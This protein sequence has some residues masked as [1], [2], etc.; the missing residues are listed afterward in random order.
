ML[1]FVSSL[2]RPRRSSRCGREEKKKGN[3][4]CVCGGDTA[5]SE[6]IFIVNGQAG[7]NGFL[8]HSRRT[9]RKNGTRITKWCCWKFI[10]FIIMQLF[11]SCF[12][13]WSLPR[14]K[15]MAFYCVILCLHLSYNCRI[16]RWHTKAI[17]R[18]FNPFHVFM[19]RAKKLKIRFLINCWWNFCPLLA[20]RVLEADNEWK[21]PKLI[22]RYAYEQQ[23]FT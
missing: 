1:H 3:Y 5:I 2:R 18:Q 7:L 12:C 11:F 13:L 19:L 21:S 23:S 9:S 8:N 10:A 20:F 6:A 16:P 14:L 17:S 15:R 22:E 4:I